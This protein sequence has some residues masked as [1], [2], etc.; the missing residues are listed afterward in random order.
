MMQAVWCSLDCHE[1]GQPSSWA[2]VLRQNEALHSKIAWLAAANIQA[3]QTRT[4]SSSQ[5]ANS[6]T[7]R[8][9]IS[10]HPLQLQQPKHNDGLCHAAEHTKPNLLNVCVCG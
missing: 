6:L 7:W 4:S 1:T 8:R 10:E 2:Q 3:H 5:A 9:T